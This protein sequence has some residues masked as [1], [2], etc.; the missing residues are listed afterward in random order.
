M[1][2]EIAIA[3]ITAYLGRGTAVAAPNLPN[4]TAAMADAAA[5]PRVADGEYQDYIN[6]IRNHAYNANQIDA[7]V[8]EMQQAKGLGVINARLAANG[9]GN[10]DGDV[11]TA[12][13][14]LDNG[15]YTPAGGVQ[16]NNAFRN[17]HA[18]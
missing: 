4:R 11:V 15:P 3:K 8:G 14:D 18:A 2:K 7:F 13:N 9:C 1:H 12:L 17:P 5:L 6:F 10:L 16:I